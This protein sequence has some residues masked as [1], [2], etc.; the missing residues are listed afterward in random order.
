MQSTKSLTL[1][2]STIFE[3]VFDAV[4]NKKVA[5]ALTLAENTVFEGIF[6]VSSNKIAGK[7]P[8]SSRKNSI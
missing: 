8:H 3:G 5:K 6:G 7:V 4:R 1:V 2:E